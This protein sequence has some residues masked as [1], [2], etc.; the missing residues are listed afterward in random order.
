MTKLSF[1][2]VKAGVFDDTQVRTLARDEK[3][4][5]KMNDKER[6]AW[7]SFV[8]VTRNFL[9]NK[10]TDNYHVLVTTVL[11]DYRGLG[12]KM[13]IKLHFLHSHLDKFPSNPEAVSD[14]QCEWFHQNLMTIE[15]RYQGLWYRN[16]MA[17][18]CCSIKQ[19]FPDEVCK[20]RSY[21]SK[22][23]PEQGHITRQNFE[24]QSKV[25]HLHFV[26]YTKN[27]FGVPCESGYPSATGLGCGYKMM[28][29]GSRKRIVYDEQ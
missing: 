9:G 8:A 10:K 3:F 27:L 18:Y 4:V 28:K 14:E 15:H 25:Q 12:C 6:A 5:N 19:D 17:D 16:M 22:F 7:L 2:K 21:K 11:L 29:P 26:C 23:L 24:S 13:S 20:R 1:D